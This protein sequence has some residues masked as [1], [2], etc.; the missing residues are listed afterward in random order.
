MMRKRTFLLMLVGTLL[1]SLQSLSAK[2]KA[3]KDVK[4][5]VA[6]C[7]DTVI[8][9]QPFIVTYRLTAKMWKGGCR[10]HSANGF[11]LKD[12][13]YSQKND[14]PYSQLL[15]KATYITSLNGQA[16]LPSMVVTVGD[17][18]YR[19]E[20]KTIFVQKNKQYGEEMSYAHEWLL[21]QGKHPDSLCLNMADGNQYF[22]LFEDRRNNSFCLMARKAWWPL[23]GIPVLAYSTEAAM[24]IDKNKKMHESMVMP[25]AQQ[26]EALKI[27]AGKA[28]TPLPYKP[29][30]SIINPLLGRLEWGQ[31]EPYNRVSPT[32]NGR[33]MIVGCVPLATAMIGYYHQWPAKGQSHVYYQNNK[34]Y[35]LDFSTTEPRWNAYK[36]SYQKNDSTPGLHNLSQL[37]T[38]IGLSVDA[39]FQNEATSA[40][41]GNVKHVLCNNLDYSGKMAFYDDCL[42]EAETEALLYYELDHRRPCI[43]SNNG[44]A[45]V[46]DG[47]KDGF[48]H[49]N[50]GWHGAYN[51]YYRLKLG[52]YQTNENLLLIKS[53]ICRIEPQRKTLERE[54]TL[55]EAGSLERLLTPLEKETITSLKISGP[56]NS[57][58]IML[59][60]K[61]AGALSCDV[62][63]SWTGGA[64]VQLNLE[65]ATI[66]ADDT[67]YFTDKARTTWTKWRTEGG[68]TR[69]TVYDFSSMTEKQ[70]KE[71]K[72][73]IGAKQKGVTYSRKDDNTYWANYICQKDIVG[74]Y[75]FADC[76]SIRK[77]VLPKTTQGIDD[78][79]F[80][81][82]S[83]LQTIRLP[84]S[85]KKV[86][87]FPFYHCTSLEEIMAPRA[88]NISLNIAEKCSPALQEITQY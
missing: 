57:R 33:K 12:A 32:L 10:P 8:Q 52:N 70:W 13:S 48:F 9:G 65:N 53:V 85:T 73:D 72:T 1:S 87:K 16:E 76:S 44:H 38:F 6:I 68:K 11:Q 62:F 40:Y 69:T 71:F 3:S 81:N 7:P 84:E 50:L 35:K 58:D 41:L 36:P 39:K 67:P 31:S 2:D 30:N 47:Y 83:S 63:S 64:L 78:Y 80:F 22:W 56:L 28:A 60:R 59:L 15:T 24:Y 23:V 37:L 17:K 77:I 42:S 74:K 46:C 14:R 20:A 19:S 75:M 82:C 43:V 25:F 88:I 49:F 86:G 4:S 5:F 54:V 61:M 27:S 34:S 66:L 45:F 29:Q 79:A 18:K 26:M 55:T 51:G 21:K